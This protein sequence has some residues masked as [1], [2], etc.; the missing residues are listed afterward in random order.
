M[1][2]VDLARAI[3]PALALKTIGI[4]PGEKVHEVMISRDDAP[5]TYEFGN[6]FIIQPSYA[7][8]LQSNKNFQGKKVAPDFAYSS[9]N[10]LDWCTIDQ[11]KHMIKKLSL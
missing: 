7:E 1:K 6:Y 4:R 11:M 3:A 10:N 5:R 9:E 2:I 8:H